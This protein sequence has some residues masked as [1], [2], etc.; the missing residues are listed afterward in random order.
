[1]AFHQQSPFHNPRIPFTGSIHGGLQDGK[2]ITVTGR[3]LPGADRFH[4]NLQSGSKANADIA[5]HINPRYD[6]FLHYVVT[7]TL[8]YGSWGSEERKLNSPFPV[9]SSFTLVI[10][11]RHDAYQLT[12]NGCHLM[13]YR[14]RIPFSMVDTISV[15]GKVEVFSIAFQS[16]FMFPPQCSFPTQ[17][18]FPPQPGFPAYP[19]FPPQ[20]GFPPAM[21]A[22]PYKSIL[23]GGLHPGRTITIQGII[24]P[25][26]TRFHVNLSFHSGIALHYNPRFSENT[27]V[28]NTKL[29]EQWGSEE[30][31]G[32]MPF[33]RGQPF[34]LTICCEAHMFRI[35]VNGNQTPIYKHRHTPLQQI[36]I[37]EI[38]G[39]LSL[40]SVLL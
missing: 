23:S 38:D 7:N 15:A 25:N 1:M 31:S 21:P 34:T 18:A 14:H 22:V 20:P 8:Q 39:D 32:G 37:L 12:V 29:R 33:H 4:V 24:S 3:V 26:A 9:G 16:S 2:I 10:T 35:V 17:S 28:R 5:L 13:D 30:R 36:D 40:T 19:G 11:V 27:V 6:S